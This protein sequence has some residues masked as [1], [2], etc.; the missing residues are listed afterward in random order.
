MV[1]A[2]DVLGLRVTLFANRLVYHFCGV[3]CSRVSVSS[4]ETFVLKSGI[5]F[6]LIYKFINGFMNL[7]ILT[8]PHNKAEST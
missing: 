4:P 8:L 3:S 6:I 5:V 1:G 2:L 7:S